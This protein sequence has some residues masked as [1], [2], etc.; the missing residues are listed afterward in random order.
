MVAGRWQLASP[1][2]LRQTRHPGETQRL[3]LHIRLCF[4]CAVRLLLLLP[5]ARATCLLPAACLPA[6]CCCCCCYFPT[7][8]PARCLRSDSA[9]DVLGGN[10]C[11]VV[12]N[13]PSL[14]FHTAGAPIGFLF[15]FIVDWNSPSPSPPARGSGERRPSR[16][17]PSAAIPSNSA[18]GIPFRP[19]LSLPPH[20]TH[21]A[22]PFAIL[23]PRSRAEQTGRTAGRRVLAAGTLWRRPLRYSR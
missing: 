20:P 5:A 12:S 2:R 10:A 3:S 21:T 16:V 23:P 18:E 17:T 4:H 22:V 9:R 15:F 14:P 1:T 13:L 11:P 19:I 8:T 6:C 7:H